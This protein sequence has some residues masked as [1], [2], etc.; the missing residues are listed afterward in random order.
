MSYNR[1]VDKVV[2][3]TGAASG[4]GEKAAKSFAEESAQVVVADIN[5]EEG[6]R[7]VDEIKEA[8]GEAIFV[9]ADSSQ[10][11]DNRKM[12]QAAVDQYGKLDSVV[13][14]AGINI[15]AKIADLSV[16]DYKKVRS[17]NLDGT[18]YANKFAV[19]Q[20]LKQGNG[21]SIVNIGSIH[22]HVARE[23]LTAYATTKGGIQML[24]KQVGTDY[25]D[26]G[27]R[28]NMVCPAYINTP[29]TETVAPEIR[30][31]LANMHPIKRMGEVDEVSAAILFLASD[32]ASFITGSD[33]KVDGGY[34]AV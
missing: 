28:C 19:E 25:A 2:I 33:V 23:G 16:E 10:E 4:I 22:S 8:G 26:Q 6:Q 7:V 9:H 5:D 24:T 13:A 17:I 15:E 32:D 14:N 1:F 20:F 27:I 30:K 12:I 21:G 11:A 34:T 3:V 18:F 31:E 29:L